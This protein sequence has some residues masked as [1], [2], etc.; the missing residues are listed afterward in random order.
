MMRRLYPGS[1]AAAGVM[2]SLFQASAVTNFSPGDDAWRLGLVV[3][4][5]ILL[6]AMVGM[7]GIGLS[8]RLEGRVAVTWWVATALTFLGLVV[9]HVF[10][11]LALFAIAIVVA[12]RFGARWAAGFTAV[13]GVTW[14]LIYLLGARVGNEDARVLT[15]AETAIALVS[16]AC[17]GIG[18]AGA[19]WA[20]AREHRRRELAPA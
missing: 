11:A 20:I 19:A 14:L 9:A 10:W 12:V 3:H 18:L 16:L 7:V 13:G 5:L 8:W 17:M 6:L 15:S 2:N 4:G 1:I